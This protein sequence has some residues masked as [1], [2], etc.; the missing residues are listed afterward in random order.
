M[1][2]SREVPLDLLNCAFFSPFSVHK[3]LTNKKFWEE[4]TTNFP[5]TVILLSDTTSRKKTVVCMDN[6][7]N[8]TIQF[9]RL[10]CLYYWWE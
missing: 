10:Q 6:E 9:E 3:I 7:V 1:E 8:K 2:W 5:I 4:L